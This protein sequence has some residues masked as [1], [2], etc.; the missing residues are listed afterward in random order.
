MPF[1]SDDLDDADAA[2]A[3]HLLDS[4]MFWGRGGRG[5]VPYLLAKRDFLREEVGW[6][7]TIVAP[8]SEVSVADRVDCGGLPL[9][10][11]GCRLPLRRRAIARL[12]EQQAPDLIEAGDPSPLGW[13][14]LDAAQR[15]G[16][17]A[18]A[19]CH[20]NPADLALRLTG[21]AQPRRGLLTRAV[22]AYLRRLYSEFDMVLAPSDSMAREL[23]DL[24]VTRVQRQPLGIDSALFHPSRRDPAWRDGLGIAPQT[25]VLV[26]AGRFSADKRLPL[27]ADAVRKLGPDHALVAIGDGPHPPRGRQ[28]WLLPAESRPARLARALASADAFV[29]AG[30]SEVFGATALQAMAC[31]TPVVLRAAGALP[32]LLDGGGGLAV[33]SNRLDPWLEAITA[34][35]AA[36]R[37]HWT[38]AAR[39]RAVEH[40]WQNV[41]PS[42]VRRY[43]FVLDALPNAATDARL[44]FAEVTQPAIL[45]HQPIAAKLPA[46]PR[47]ETR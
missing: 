37:E 44:S 34:V 46:A 21:S 31:G 45:W 6:R 17:P 15:L 12:I 47:S 11:S 2:P 3:S 25:R 22:G 27:L 43:R 5:V 4:T 40:D 10:G 7:H 20:R 35:F 41:L 16:V 18:V 1:I 29:H 9:P 36:G 42:L 19:F 38:H 23:R 28:V 14:S 32:E 8:G 26:Y 24:G 33:R 13:A 30:E 39:A